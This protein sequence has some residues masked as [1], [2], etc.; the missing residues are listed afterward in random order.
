VD[1]TRGGDSR[2]AEPP[3]WLAKQAR[4]WV[5]ALHVQPAARRTA[6]TG[7]Y[8]DRLKIAVTAPADGG[9]ANAQLVR[10][11]ATQL[12]VASAT[13]ELLSGAASRDKRVAIPLNLAAE[14]IVAALAPPKKEAGR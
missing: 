2:T 6:I 5:V 3:A 10:F 1:S 13:V 9:R 8:G 4:C 14:Q 7:L 11:I 12:R